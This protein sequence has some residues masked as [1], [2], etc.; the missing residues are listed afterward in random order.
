MALIV[1]NP[2]AWTTLP[3]AWQVKVNRGRPDFS[4]SSEGGEPCIHLK[5]SRASF[6]LERQ[7]DVDPAQLPFLGWRW[8]VVYL[9][10][11]GDFRRASTDD[12][13]AQVLVAFEDRR[14]LSYIWD[15]SAPKETA[16]RAG[17]IPLLHIFTVVCESGPADRNRWMRE[18]RNVAGDYVRA[19][20]KPAPRVRGLRIQINSQHTGTFA[21][22]YFGEIAFRRAPLE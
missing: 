1:L 15:T 9:P 22:S 13:A 18:N 12:Q 20:G 8:K 16:Q 2:A 19:Y 21:E 14:V 5:S 11:G 7:V 6:A 10:A 4:V 3:P 17:F